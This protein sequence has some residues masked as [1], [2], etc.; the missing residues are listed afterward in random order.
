MNRKFGQDKLRLASQ[1]CDHE[2]PMHYQ[3]R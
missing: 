1:H 3:E 2:W